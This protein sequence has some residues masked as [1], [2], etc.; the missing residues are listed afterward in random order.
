MAERVVGRGRRVAA[1]P[2][3]R[4]GL[5]VAVAAGVLAAPAHATV[6]GT[7]GAFSAAP[8]R[9]DINGEVD[10]NGAVVLRQLPG[11]DDWAHLVF[12]GGGIGSL[13][14][15]APPAVTPDDEPPIAELL[16]NAQAIEHGPIGTAASAP[17]APLAPFTP[18]QLIPTPPAANLLV[19]SRLRIHPAHF[20]RSATVSY[21]LSAPGQ[22]RFTI[23]PCR[24]HCTFTRSGRVGTNTFCLRSHGLRPGRHRLS[25]QPVQTGAK[26]STV[27]FRINAE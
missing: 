13:G 15:P 16:A 25:A 6:P 23:T 2:W 20:Q 3:R 11:F 21:R 24:V 9:A 17:F 27:S 12:T 4:A 7:N 5:V 22:V 19:L 14:A 26:V 18:A 1:A 8:V 10:K